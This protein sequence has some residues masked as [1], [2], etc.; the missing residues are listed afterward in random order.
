ML[1]KPTEPHTR[2]KFAFVRESSPYGL[3]PLLHTYSS[4]LPRLAQTADLTLSEL[5][6]VTANPIVSEMGLAT[7]D[8]ILSELGLVLS[9][10]T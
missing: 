8:L 3:L 1:S 7:A 9:L 2:R 4:R 6:L 10:R 5:G